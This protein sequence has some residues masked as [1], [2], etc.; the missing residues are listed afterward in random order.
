MT[1]TELYSIPDRRFLDVK[2]SL[3]PSIP[4]PRICLLTGLATSSISTLF[5]AGRAY[6]LP[7]TV[8]TR[9]GSDGLLSSKPFQVRENVRPCG[10]AQQR[11]HVPLHPAH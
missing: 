2:Q 9:I 5:R 4:R 10:L 8:T 6:P 1:I 7:V 11:L 3:Q